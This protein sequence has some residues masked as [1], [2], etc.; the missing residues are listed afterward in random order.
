[1]TENHVAQ[2]IFIAFVLI[3]LVLTWWAGK[4]NHTEKDYYTAGGAISPLKNGLAIAGDAVSASAFLGMT[5][6]IFYSGFDP[7]LIVICPFVWGAIMLFCVVDRFRNLGDC[8]FV[9]VISYRLKDGPVRLIF[10]LGGLITIAFYLTAQLVGAGKLIELIFG[11]EY[12]YAVILIVSLT[13]VYISIGGMLA[14][15]WIQMFK[16]ALLVGSGIVLTGII[17]THFNFNFSALLDAATA[18]HTRGTEILGPGIYYQNAGSIIATALTVVCGFL[19]LPHVLIR[20]FTVKNARDARKS[21]FYATFIMGAFHLMIIIMGFA[22]IAFLTGNA[23]YFTATGEVLAGRNMVVLHLSKFLLGDFM[24]GFMSAV[25]FATILAV[26]SG[27][28]IAGAVSISH[29]L[30]A[31]RS[32]KNNKHEIAVFR[33]SAVM[34]CVIGVICAVFFENQNVLFIAVTALSIAASVNFPILLLSIYSKSLTSNGAVAGGVVGLLV[35]LILIVLSKSIM[36]DI[37]GAQQALYPYSY[38]T[39]ISLP[40]ALIAAFCFSHFDRSPRAIKEREEFK[41][42]QYKS[43]LI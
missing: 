23:E 39:I 14:A 36:V 28:I 33:I 15:T 3:T 38:P 27:L 34:L 1:M 19:G 24:L 31:Q 22:A 5:S 16:A 42:Q 30:Y 12:F 40:A 9:D 17:L 32:S 43:E 13:I 8:S 2:Y 18:K 4:K 41:S 37:F 26:V 21:I 6:A 7:L 10:S 25:T 35:S 11:I 29:D 20:I